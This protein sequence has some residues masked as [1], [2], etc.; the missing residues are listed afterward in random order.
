M[1][2]ILKPSNWKIL[3]LFYGNKNEPIHLRDISRK[4]K[5]NEST[6]STHLNKLVKEGILKAEKEANLKKFSIYKNQIPSI[7]PL[8][9]Y[10]RLETLPLVRRDAIK[11]YIQKLD[12]KPLL[13]IVF[14]STAKGNFRKDSD[15]DILVIFPEKYNDEKTIDYVNSQTGIKIQTFKITEEQFN[16][17]LKLKK[18]RVVQSALETGFPVF[19][20]KYYY[21]VINDG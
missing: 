1:K 11:L 12:K 20:E 4:I 3:E 15:I 21:E 17:E 16:E 19:N 8:F 9:D 10:E 2:T 5:L 18:D 7:F 14:G 13:V 6:T